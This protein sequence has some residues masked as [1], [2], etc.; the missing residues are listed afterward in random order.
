MSLNSI[1]GYIAIAVVLAGAAGYAVYQSRT[2]EGLKTENT[3]L[4]DKVENLEARISLFSTE[5]IRL[6][7]EL[8]AYQQKKAEIEIRYLERPV[9][10][11]VEVI[12]EVPAELATEQANEETN[13]IFNNVS[14]RAIA[15]SLHGNPE[16]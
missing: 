5:K 6:T 2:I 15:F 8:E 16:N 11:F 10:K 13:A 12:K 14:S 7:D 3:L 4:E 9:V 1:Y